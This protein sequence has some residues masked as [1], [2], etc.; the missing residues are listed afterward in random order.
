MYYEPINMFIFYD[1]TLFLLFIDLASIS[2]KF[3]KTD[4]TLI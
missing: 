1:L 4:F 3:M 2:F